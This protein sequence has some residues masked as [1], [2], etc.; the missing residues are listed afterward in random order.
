MTVSGGNAERGGWRKA[1]LFASLALAPFAVLLVLKVFV[2]PRPYWAF[3]FDPEVIFYLSGIDIL[4]GRPPSNTDHPGLTLEVLTAAIAAVTGQSPLDVDAFRPVAYWT[5]FALSFAAVAMLRQTLLRGLATVPAL[6]CV[7]TYFL[8]PPALSRSTIWSPETLFLAFGGIAI[9]LAD[10]CIRDPASRRKA[11]ACGL[12]IGVCVALKFTLGV[13]APAFAVAFVYSARRRGVRVAAPLAC[14]AACVVAGFVIAT[15]PAISR[16]PRMFGF[17]SAQ[18]ANS[19]MYGRGETEAPRVGSIVANFTAVLRTASVWHA[20]LGLCGAAAAWGWWR[21]RLE[22]RRDPRYVATLL[23]GV[24][25]GVLGY[26]GLIRTGN[27]RYLLVAG[28]ASIALTAA[29]ARSFEARPSRAANRG[30][31]AVAGALFALMIVRDLADHRVW[32]RH[33]AEHRE[34]LTRA[35]DSCRKAGPEPVIV[36]GRRSPDPAYA[37]GVYA[38]TD[39]QRLEIHDRFPTTGW[40]NVWYPHVDLPPGVADW[41]YLVLP[42]MDVERFPFEHGPVCA[43]VGDFV[44]LARR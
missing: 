38:S 24:T 4:E 26:A 28:V 18:I 12:A 5:A 39:A 36:Y 22:L 14:A 34:A 15:I 2:Y 33:C 8:C 30:F 13:L 17:M 31:G 21:A 32:V 43:T 29:I 27:V 42:A 6:A 20:W 1:M 3:F 41:D 23:F 16:Y 11:A 25:A 9:A 7:W 37:L 44:V 35:V 40:F 19:G 10:R